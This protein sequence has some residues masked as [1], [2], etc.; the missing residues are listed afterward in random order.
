MFAVLI[1]LAVLSSI[2]FVGALSESNLPYSEPPLSITKIETV[3][4][5]L[6]LDLFNKGTTDI[7]IDKI[8]VNGTVL[9]G[10]IFYET[11][12]S[13]VPANIT[14][15]IVFDFHWQAKNRYVITLVYQQGQTTIMALTP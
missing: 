13:N 8:V 4:N 1:F 9:T 15:T 7:T 6:M 10:K 5:R 3:P 12:F 2:V 11:L 14:T